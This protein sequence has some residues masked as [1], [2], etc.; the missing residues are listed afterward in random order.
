ME[1]KNNVTTYFEIK[2][3]NKMMW[4]NHG[5]GFSLCENEE[6][7]YRWDMSWETR[8]TKESVLGGP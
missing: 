6:L 5:E 8:N 1:K 7:L 3:I 4:W 2:W